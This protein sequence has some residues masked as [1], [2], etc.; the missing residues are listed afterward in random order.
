MNLMSVDAVTL[1]WHN[2]TL[3]N[4]LWWLKRFRVSKLEKI[5]DSEATEIGVKN[6]LLSLEL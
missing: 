2:R 6:A 3:N 1:G 5:C 4:S